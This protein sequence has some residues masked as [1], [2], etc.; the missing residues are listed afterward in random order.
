MAVV[1][2]MQAV[3]LI[4]IFSSNEDLSMRRAAFFVLLNSLALHVRKLILWSSRSYI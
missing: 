3:W 1:Y 2:G 4:E